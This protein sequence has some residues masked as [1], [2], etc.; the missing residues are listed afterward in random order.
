MK[1]FFNR[2]GQ[3]E[4]IGLVI[5]VILITVG[6]LFMAQF[7]LK[8]SPTKKIF[9]RKGLA[10]STMSAIMK[11]TVTEDCGVSSKFPQIEKELLEDCAANKH[12]TEDYYTYHCRGYISSCDFLEV[13]I[14]ERLNETLGRWN[15]RYEFKSVLV[16]GS[17]DSLFDN[18]IISKRGGCPPT[19]N[20]DTSS[21]YPLNTDVGLVE[22][23][24]YI[25][26]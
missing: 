11:T 26:D 20:R 22:S 9:T 17:A 1:P 19:K 18:P 7:A 2:S 3:T 24:L 23:T 15:K 12:F 6:I 25:C 8:E 4:M 13:F 16:R 5:I 21:P 14:A 10:T